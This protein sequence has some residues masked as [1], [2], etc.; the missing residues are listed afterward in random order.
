MGCCGG[1]IVNFKVVYANLSERRRMLVFG[2]NLRIVTF[3]SLLALIP[4]GSAIGKT[5][6]EE[7]TRSQCEAAMSFNAYS[8]LAGVACNGIV[9]ENDVPDYS[10]AGSTCNRRYG[11]S[12]MLEAGKRGIREFKKD[13]QEKGQ[14]SLCSAIKAFLRDYKVPGWVLGRSQASEK[15]P[16]KEQ[17][18]DALSFHGTIRAAEKECGRITENTGMPDFQGAIDDCKKAYGASYVSKHLESGESEFARSL[19]RR[20]HE[21]ACSAATRVVKDYMSDK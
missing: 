4:S 5:Q 6:K 17:C 13:A 10:K 1:A 3:V 20:G 11:E 19:S 2:D 18:A 16:S 15:G 8:I 9:A 7:P 14:D 21:E 12:A